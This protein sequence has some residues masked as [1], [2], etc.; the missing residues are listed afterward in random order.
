MNKPS[1]AKVLGAYYTD[2]RVASFLVNWAIRTEHDLVMDPAFG[3]GVFLDAVLAKLTKSHSSSRQVYGVE[4]DK[5]IYDI[6]IKKLHSRIVI[7]NLVNA[8]FFELDPQQSRLDE[9]QVRIPPLDAIVGNPPF[10]RYHRFKG[11]IRRRAQQKTSALGVEF[12]GL[13]SSWAPFVVHA[14]SFLRPGGRLAMVMPV[15]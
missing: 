6:V 8:D 15:R 10:I 9:S 3:N 12:N 7:D 13:S 5:N 14:A 11:E 1:P 2:P 4:I